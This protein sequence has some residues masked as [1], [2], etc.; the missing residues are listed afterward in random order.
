MTRMPHLAQIDWN[1]ADEMHHCDLGGGGHVHYA[2]A[3]SGE[4]VRKVWKH[5]G[6]I[7]ERIYLGGFELYRR[8]LGGSIEL[9]RETVHLTDGTHRIAMVETKTIG[10]AS[11]V[12]IP[13]ARTRYQLG[14]LLGSASLEVDEDG[15]VISYEE[16]HPYGTSAY[17]AFQ[18]EVSAKRYRYIACERDDE[19]GLYLMGARYYAAWL[20][21]W[22]AADPAGTVDGTN[23]YAYVRGSPVG[24]RD[25]SGTEAISNIVGRVKTWTGERIDAAASGQSTAIEGT[26][27][28]DQ[29]SDP[30]EAHIRYL[31]SR[32]VYVV[33]SAD[34]EE[35]RE[36]IRRGYAEL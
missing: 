2:Y 9:E 36:E 13:I 27:E 25:P 5:N 11:A 1:A 15:A 14:N 16:Y 3:A 17:R 32:G 12:E 7:E 6:L 35:Q 10:Q 4:R 29:A 19:T 21:R 28:T 18:G 23:L 30:A 22:T 20:G 34:P 8:R 33:N 24:L 26:P 31:L